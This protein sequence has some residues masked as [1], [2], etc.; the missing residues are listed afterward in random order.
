MHDE[1]IPFNDLSRAYRETKDEIDRSISR[2]LDRGAYVLG[3]E[4]QAFEEEFAAYLG[5][6]H[7][8]GVG[9]GTDAL[10]LAMVALAGHSGGELVLASNAGGY[11]SVAAIKSGLTP[12][13]A[14]V[15][16]RTLLLTAES[17]APHLNSR[18]AAVVVTHLYGQM[19]DVE[20][21]VDLCR[22]FHIPVIEDCAQSVGATQSGRSAGSI[23]DI[24]TFSFY[25]TKNLG[26]LGDAGAV[27]TSDADLQQRLVRLRQYGWAER[28]VIT[29]G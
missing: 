27:V 11:A 25:P 22:S 7:C 1:P 16:A 5:I 13:Y 15:S 6:P 14:E 12:R 9:N 18:T 29:I 24:G 28:G 21:I 8:V 20:P 19:A 23:G 3:P 26:A 4:V 17:I 2:V 10:E